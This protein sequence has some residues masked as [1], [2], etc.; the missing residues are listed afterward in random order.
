VSE[1]LARFA[2]DAAV[3]PTRLLPDAADEQALREDPSAPYEVAAYLPDDE[4]AA[5]AVDSAERALWHL[6]AF[7]LRP[8]GEL[9]LRRVEER[10]WTEA[11]RE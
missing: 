9:R 8:V 4:R 11:W 3:R 10:D 1:V 5:A 2:S 6:Q 7:G